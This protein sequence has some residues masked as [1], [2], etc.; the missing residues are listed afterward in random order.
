DEFFGA[1]QVYRQYV[2]M[3]IPAGASG[4]VN[5]SWQGCADAGLCYPPQSQTIDLGGAA[6][7]AAQG[8]A[9]D[10]SLA[11][12]LQQRSLGWSLLLFFGLG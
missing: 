10:Q 5:V 11:A 4:K 12:S 9:Q 2:E 3:L 8:Q 1:S 6:P 7:V